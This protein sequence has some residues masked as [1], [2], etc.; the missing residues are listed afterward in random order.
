MRRIS[1][2]II[3]PGLN[4]KM[5]RHRTRTFR[6]FF[7][8]PLTFNPAFTGKIDGDFRVAGNYRNQWPT[9]NRAYNTTTFSV[10][11]PIL[12]NSIAPN[13]T[14]GVGHYGLLRPKCQ[15]CS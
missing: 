5:L 12:R 13:D 2:F 10:D 3:F 7:A 11:F 15:Q 9:I 6:Q 4:S 14:W 8:S 1:T